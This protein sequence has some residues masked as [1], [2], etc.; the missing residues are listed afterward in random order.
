[1]AFNSWQASVKYR[2]THGNRRYDDVPVSCIQIEYENK[3]GVLKR[4]A[5]KPESVNDFSPNSWYIINSN[6]DVPDGTVYPFYAL[7]GR[8]AGKYKLMW[9]AV[10]RG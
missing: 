3:K 2:S 1:M 8:I 10:R 5:F 7:I 6:K 4:K 9:F